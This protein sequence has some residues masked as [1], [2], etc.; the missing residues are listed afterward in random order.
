[1]LKKTHRN[2]RARGVQSGSLRKIKMHAEAYFSEYI[3][4]SNQVPAS[5]ERIF[6]LPTLDISSAGKRSE[7]GNMY[8]GLALKWQGQNYHERFHVCDP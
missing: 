2:A 6:S 4:K 3:S 1:M 8:E 5:R 7:Y